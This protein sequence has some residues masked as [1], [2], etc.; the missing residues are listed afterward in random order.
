MYITSNKKLSTKHQPG[1]F[2]DEPVSQASS[3]HC[4][5]KVKNCTLTHCSYFSCILFHNSARFK[6]ILSESWKGIPEQFLPTN[7]EKFSHPI[8]QKDQKNNIKI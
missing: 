7:L 8:S 5:G 2:T 1:K 3:V 6:S 4:Q